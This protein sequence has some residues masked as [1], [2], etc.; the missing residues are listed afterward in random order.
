MGL[1]LEGGVTPSE[2]QPLPDLKETMNG[3]AER[4]K[5]KNT[6][7]G[8]Q[9][10]GIFGQGE[11]EALIFPVPVESQGGGDSDETAFF[12]PKG[13]SDNF[14]VVTEEGFKLIQVDK[15]REIV[16][17]HGGKSDPQLIAN[18][19]REGQTNPSE[20]QAELGLRRDGLYLDPSLHVATIGMSRSAQ[21][22][23]NSV[24]LVEEVDPDLVVTIVKTNMDRIESIKR[25]E[26]ERKLK[27]N[28]EAAGKLM[29]LLKT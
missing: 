7:L 11:S 2:Q 5:I 23:G 22:L 16:D 19:V 1:N 17:R 27:P 29:G 14:L 4:L 20:R 26:L 3:V 24:R 9:L 10:L 12:A 18:I 13:M 6:E 21:F 15:T 8:G 28:I 25:E